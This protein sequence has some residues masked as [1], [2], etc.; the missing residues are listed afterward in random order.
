[1]KKYLPYVIVFLFAVLLWDA[2]SYS[3]DW[4]FHLDDDEFEGPFGALL[5]LVLAGGGTLLG[6]LITLVVG[7]VLAVVFA[8]LGVLLLGGLCIGAVA[9]A[10]LVSPLLLPLLLPLALVWYLVSRSRRQRAAAK[11]VAA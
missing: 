3:G 10:L 4:M 9:L 5:G 6:L 1:M 8:G 2:L 7:V 11:T